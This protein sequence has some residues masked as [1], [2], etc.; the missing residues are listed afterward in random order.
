MDN[1]SKTQRHKNMQ[2]IRSHGSKI[3]TILGK[4]LW[5]V[6]LRYRKNCQTIFGK[7]DFVMPRYK[8][9]IFCDSEFWHGKDWAEAK[10]NIKSNKNFWYRKISANIERDKK[11][12]EILTKEGWKVFRFWGNDILKSTDKCIN[13]I[14]HYIQNHAS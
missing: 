1:L 7:P 10:F 8:I 3:E 12:N 6:R 11:V 5:K 2:A 9:V 13:K 14:E 4:T